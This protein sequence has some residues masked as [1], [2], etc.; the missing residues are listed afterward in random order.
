MLQLHYAGETVLMA[1]DVCNALLR[2]ARALADTHTSDIVSVP[3]VSD[4]GE[5]ATA[6]F[7][8]GPASQ[9]FAVPMPGMKD[10]GN[11]VTVVEDLDHRAGMLRPSQASAL[12]PVDPE[13]FID[14][15]QV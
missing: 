9:L 6:E 8:L 13:T 4:A 1:N 14:T 15:D 5:V 3:V 11:D 2:Y 12:D 10:Q 7:L